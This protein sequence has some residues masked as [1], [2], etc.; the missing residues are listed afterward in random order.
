MRIFSLLLSQNST[1]LSYLSQEHLPSPGNSVPHGKW[2]VG[3]C[4]VLLHNMSTSLRNSKLVHPKQGSHSNCFTNSAP[5]TE[6]DSWWYFPAWFSLLQYE[7]YKKS[8]IQMHFFQTSGLCI[9]EWIDCR[10]TRCKKEANK[11][12]RK[13]MVQPR[14]LSPGD[15]IQRIEKWAQYHPLGIR[16]LVFNDC[17]NFTAQGF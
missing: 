10:T 17:R 2:S 16:I 13:W 5:R 11:F 1:G 8:Y 4:P 15:N 3:T 9:R 7:I 6:L 12:R 14:K